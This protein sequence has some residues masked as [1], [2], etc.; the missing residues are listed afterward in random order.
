MALQSQRCGVG[1]HASA[2][3]LVRGASGKRPPVMDPSMK[4]TKSSGGASDIAAWNASMP[5]MASIPP[6]LTS[7]DRISL[8]G[9]VSQVVSSLGV[10]V[11][12]RERVHFTVRVIRAMSVL[13]WQ[14]VRVGSGMGL[15][16]VQEW[17]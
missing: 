2:H 16:L 7:C 4:A 15:G 12:A 10:R 5:K 17:A 1:S 6:P 3:P 8:K 11:R 13:E 14:G 9:A